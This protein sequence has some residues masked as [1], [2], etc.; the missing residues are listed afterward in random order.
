M[1]DFKVWQ[2]EG[3]KPIKAWING[4]EAE[5]EALEQVQAVS[6]MPFVFPHVA[7]MP[8]VHHGIGATVG[9]VIPTRGAII[10]AAVGVDIGC[11]MM[12]LRT[13]LS[14]SDLPESLASLRSD[15]ERAVPHGRTDNGG[16]GDRGAW[17]N[18]PKQIEDTAAA[19]IQDP[20]I[21]VLNRHNISVKR[22]AKQVGSLGSGNHFI[23]I[24]LDENQ[25][26]WVMLHSGS[27][28]IGNIVG[29]HY[30]DRAKRLAEQ[31]FVSLPDRDLAYL[32][33]GTK[34]F[35]DYMLAVEWAQEYALENRR[36]MLV[37]VLD[38]LADSGLPPFKIT[39]EGRQ[40]P[41]QLRRARAPLQRQ[42]CT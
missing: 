17:H 11:G 2:P 23:E 18:L 35:E 21:E 10:P 36:R 27:R 7:V 9:S 24:C 38:V 4:V 41:P 30:I 33:D 6:R 16:S 42:P 28:G 15:I 37:S 40:L 25:D 1:S 13:H 34:D 29:R 39:D 26:V 14:A 8:D 22:A 12:A 31:F 19:L 20:A 5:P 3:G 32:P